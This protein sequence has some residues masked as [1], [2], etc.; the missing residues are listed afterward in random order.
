MDFPPVWHDRPPTTP[1]TTS[2]CPESGL[3]LLLYWGSGMERPIA[4]AA[5]ACPDADRFWVSREGR[6]LGFTPAVPLASDD[7][8]VTYGEAHFVRRP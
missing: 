2:I 7:W 1:R 5:G 4:D 3:W 6:W 8:T